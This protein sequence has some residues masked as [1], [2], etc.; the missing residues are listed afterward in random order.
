M[1]YNNSSNSSM[2]RKAKALFL[3]AM[4]SVTVKGHC[5]ALIYCKGGEIAD[6]SVCRC[7]PKFSQSA[8]KAKKICSGRCP[9]G[10]TLSSLC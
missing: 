1:F 9:I 3:L 7:V 8:P 6:Y 10:K 5:N 4:L 2:I